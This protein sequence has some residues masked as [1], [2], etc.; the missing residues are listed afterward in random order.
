MN[1]LLLLEPTKEIMLS[2]KAPS[3][4]SENRKYRNRNRS[5]EQKMPMV[6]RMFIVMKG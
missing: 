2:R 5:K 3:A 6:T 1:T 4:D